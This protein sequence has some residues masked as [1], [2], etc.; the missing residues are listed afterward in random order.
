MPPGTGSHNNVVVGS[1]DP[2][3]GTRFLPNNAD[4]SQ[5]PLNPNFLPVTSSTVN[6][7]QYS[8]KQ[9]QLE[10]R[11]KCCRCCTCK[12]CCLSAVAVL[13]VVGGVMLGLYLWFK[14]KMDAAKVG[15]A[16][17]ENNE[18]WESTLSG[19]EG[20]N[21]FTGEFQLVSYSPSYEAYLKA[22]G[23][24]GF[25][26]GFILQAKEVIKI[27]AFQN[28]TYTLHSATGF[29]EQEIFFE[30]GKEFEMTWGRNKGIMH[31]IC[32]QEGP[33]AWK[34]HSQ[35]HVKGWNVSS[36]LEF[37]DFGI[38]NTRHFVN[39]DITCKKYFKRLGMGNL[40]IGGVV[41]NGNGNVTD[42]KMFG[43]DVM[44]DDVIMINIE[45]GPTDEDSPFQDDEDEDYDFGESEM[46]LDD[47]PF[48]DDS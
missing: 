48:F 25:I 41:G 46:S 16:S 8:G 15:G 5:L 20:S 22:F 38:V 35:E 2:E 37:Y 3:E 43:D 27:R 17:S 40:D 1:G 34:F 10:S 21:N 26:V 7:A 13:V 36:K 18:L 33:N 31:S 14:A 44:G 19:G 23:I 11:R 4:K 29:S 6:G 45:E 30:M 42:A 47:D 39:E 9:Q 12:C 24:P 32:N 28:G